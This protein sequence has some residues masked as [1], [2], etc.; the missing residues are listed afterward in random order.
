MPKELLLATAPLIVPFMPAN[1][2]AYMPAKKPLSEAMVSVIEMLAGA[3]GLNS[4]PAFLKCLTT[5]R[6]TSSERPDQN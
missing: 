6:T 3:F 2:P 5:Q 1:G 4:I